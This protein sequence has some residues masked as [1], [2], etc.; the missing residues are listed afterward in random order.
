MVA[1]L[2]QCAAKTV[3]TRWPGRLAQSGTTAVA[4]IVGLPYDRRV[5]AFAGG[6]WLHG[7]AQHDRQ[8]VGIAC[9]AARL[10]QPN[11]RPIAQ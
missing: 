8:I 9:V 3:T 7:A 1:S 2:L 6:H 10:R 11:R 5:T 4:C